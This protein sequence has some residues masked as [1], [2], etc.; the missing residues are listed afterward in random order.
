MSS[1]ILT[2]TLV[3]VTVGAL[4]GYFTE[5]YNV[6]GIQEFRKSRYGPS[7]A[8]FG[9]GFVGTVTGLGLGCVAAL[10]QYIRR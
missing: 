7:L 2:T 3:G 6:V 10:Y 1:I 9:F 5:D 4:Y 8:T